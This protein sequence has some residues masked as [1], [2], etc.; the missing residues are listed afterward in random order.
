MMLTESP[1]KS[2]QESLQ[3]E[4]ITAEF[5]SQR[6]LI[7]AA[8]RAPVMFQRTESGVVEQVRGAGGLVTALTGLA[9]H[10]DATWIAC[11]RTQEDAEWRSGTV[12][13]ANSERD[14]K[15]AFIQPDPEAYEWYYNQIANPLL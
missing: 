10:V 12:K 5:L 11:A 8:N 6:H 3:L 13:L 1:G 2:T 15:V 4:A 14:M 9:Q 7:I